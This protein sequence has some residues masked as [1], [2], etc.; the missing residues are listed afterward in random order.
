MTAYTQ[1]LRSLYTINMYNPV[2]LGLENMLRLNELIGNPLRGLPIVHV[3]GT[4]GKGSVATKVARSLECLGLR[5]GLYTSPHISSFRERIQ[6]NSE[7]LAT[8]DVEEFLPYLFSVC[9][10]NKIPATFFE[11]TTALAFMKFQRAGCDAVVLEVGLGGRLDATNIVTPALSIITAIQFDH[12]NIL[13]NSLEEIAREKAGIIKKDTEVLVGPGCPHNVIRPIAASLHAPYFTLDD[14]L[15]YSERGYKNSVESDTD[16][17]NTDLSKGALKILSQKDVLSSSKYGAYEDIIARPE[18]QQALRS[19]PICRFETFKL[20]YVTSSDEKKEVDVVLDMAHN[21]DALQALAKR[22][23][24]NF[25]RHEVKLVVGM[26]ADKDVKGC[27]QHLLEMVG[28]DADRVFCTEAQTPRAM[29]IREL[30]S[31]LFPSSPALHLNDHADVCS[32]I[33]R[34]LSPL[35][36]VQVQSIQPIDVTPSSN[37]STSKTLPQLICI[38]GSAFIMSR[39]RRCIGIEEA[40]DSDDIESAGGVSGKTA[41]G[42]VFADAQENFSGKM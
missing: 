2:K 15:R 24:K 19:R 25:P 27:A 8:E 3:T 26:S 12:M 20:S 33:H 35:G 34:A 37:V 9:K 38:C 18:I 29:P 1:L 6:V 13:G 16:D 31:L 5:T 14:I 32:A 40:R 28:A 21:V 23:A 10:K 36:S 39:A 30:R 41:D 11:V 42:K 22:I 7:L 4:N 17:L